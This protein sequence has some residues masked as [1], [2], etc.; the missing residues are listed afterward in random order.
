[1]SLPEFLVRELDVHIDR[2]PSP[3]GYI[4]TATEGGPIRHATS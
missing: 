3:D 2:Y 1:M 4:F